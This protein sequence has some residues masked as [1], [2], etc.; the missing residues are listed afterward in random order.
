MGCG[1]ALLVLLAAICSMFL[2]AWV[3]TILWGW[4]F[5]AVYHLP[6][7]SLAMAM[8]C[9]LI[10]GMFRVNEYKSLP[11]TT[12]PLEKRKRYIHIFSEML[13]APLMTLLFGWLVHLAM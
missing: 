8:G 2:R 5:V 12:D 13:I 4:F 10:V 9:A 11:E 7:M 3:L 6:P 1:L